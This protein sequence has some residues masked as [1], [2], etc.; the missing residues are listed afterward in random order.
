MNNSLKKI[1]FLTVICLLSCKKDSSV[2]EAIFDENYIDIKQANS[3]AEAF[4][5]NQAGYVKKNQGK[6]ISLAPSFGKSI[7]SSIAIK[8]DNEAN[9]FYVINYEG[10]G[11]SLIS[12][13]KRTPKILA[14]S[15][16][17]YFRTDTIMP[18]IAGWVENTKAIV[19][20]IRDKNIKYTGQDMIEIYPKGKGNNRFEVKNPPIDSNCIDTYEE[21]GPL[22]QT[23]WRQE[24]GYN[25]LMP[26]I[27][28]GPDGHAYA[29]CVTTAISQ[30]IR[31]HEYPNWYNYS[32][33]PN[34]IGTNYYSSGA[35]EIASLM[36][37]S[38]ATLPT[39]TLFSIKYDCTGTY[40]DAANAVNTFVNYFGYS[41]AAQS[42]NYSSSGSTAVLNSLRAGKPVI[43]SGGSQ[44]WLGSYVNGHAWVC[45]GF[46]GGLVCLNGGYTGATEIIYLSHNWGYGGNNGNGFYID[47]GFYALGRTFNYQTK[48]IVNIA[49]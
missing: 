40:T 15:D 23:E 1:L 10:G 2:S 35:Q 29:G 7:K 22:L 33:M 17:G 46:Y 24:H 28:C 47:P 34:D 43:F 12:A 41:N 5:I 3:I 6:S 25:N 44:N 21:V 8:T 39:S 4:A 38:D 45:D 48:V 42:I 19:K 37:A 31:Y 14:F 30:I 20:D 13:D 36:A 18:G 16:K 49:P 27:P 11:F 32:I 26:T 9:A